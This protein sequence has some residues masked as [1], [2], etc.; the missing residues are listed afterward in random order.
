LAKIQKGNAITIMALL[1]S[2][3]LD[4]GFFFEAYYGEVL[5]HP[6][7]NV[8]IHAIW[9]GVATIVDHT[10]QGAFIVQMDVGVELKLK[11][12]MRQGGF[13]HPALFTVA[14]KG[15]HDAVIVA[16]SFVDSPH[17][18][19][20]LGIAQIVVTRATIVTAKFFV[21]ATL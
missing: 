9:S 6:A 3:C 4:C 10:K 16:Q 5:G 13:T 15:Y 2:L 21:G 20:V 8:I 12:R 18:D 17:V 1:L 7:C 14:E 11:T 19:V